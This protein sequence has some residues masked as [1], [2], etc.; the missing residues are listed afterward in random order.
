MGELVVALMNRLHEE[1]RGRAD[2]LMDETT[3]QGLK[4]PGKAP[5]SKSQR[6]AMRSPGPEP[7][8]VVFEYDPT[9]AGE[10]P[11]RWLAAF[12]GAL[13]TDGDSGY[14]PAVREYDLV[15]LACWAPARRGFTDVLNSLGLTAKKLPSNPPAKAR[16]ALDA[17]QR[18]RPLDAIERRIRNAPPE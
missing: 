11:M 3:V 9:R 16:R 12:T 14:A 5:E 6:W 2:G 10:V 7:P 17:P 8:I 13:H 1:L 18:I 4:E 15:H